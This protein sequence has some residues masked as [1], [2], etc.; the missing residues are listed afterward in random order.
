VQQLL[1]AAGLP[2]EDLCESHLEHFFFLGPA[3]APTALVG[4]ELYGD[5]ALLRS[6]AVSPDHRKRGLGSVMVAHVEQHVRTCGVRRI[7]LLTTTA[8]EFFASRGYQLANR[9]EAPVA[10]RKTREFADICPAS[11]AFMF[12]ILAI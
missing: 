12:K 10:I 7:F 1:G 4:A 2:T 11:S 5:N 9:E 6:L 3:S 8:Q